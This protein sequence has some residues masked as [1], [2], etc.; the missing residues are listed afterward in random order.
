MKAS[1]RSPVQDHSMH[2]K[3]EHNSEKKKK[4]REG[5]IY[6][7]YYRYRCYSIYYRLNGALRICS[8]QLEQYSISRQ[9]NVRMAPMLVVL[10]FPF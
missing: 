3:D 1:R 2:K 6:I 4:R 8:E 9:E 5:A 7:Y 10:D